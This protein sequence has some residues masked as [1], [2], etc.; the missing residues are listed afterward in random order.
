MILAAISLLLLVSLTFRYGPA[1]PPAPGGTDTLEQVTLGGLRQWISMRGADSKAPVLLFLHGGPGSA[2]LA[3]LRLQVP[4]L[5]QHFVVVNW[6]QPGAGKSASPGFDYGRLSIGQMVSD[7]HELVAYLK[8]RFGVEKIYL[9]GFSWGTVIG[10]SLAQQYPQDFLAYISVSQVVD[11][12]QGER[13]SLEFVRQKA[14]QDGNQH[15]ITALAGIN[16][17]Y[18]STD[19]LQQ[20]TTERN[21]LLHYGGVYHN[22]SSYAHEIWLLL[23]AHEYSLVEVSLWPGHSRASLKQ[24]WPEVMRVNF[25]ETVTNV[26]CPI[27]FFVGRYDYNA[28]GQLTEAY[29]QKLEAPA[30]KKLVWF[31]HSAHDIFYDEPQRLVQEVL[32][33][34]E[35]DNGGSDVVHE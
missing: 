12:A 14:A 6:D 31:E 28:P 9:M 34:L 10:L 21:W 7:A 22:T 33:V 30:G 35:A 23:E 16:P 4:E 1:H 32:A 19:W 8:A 20:V 2:N 29:Y 5:E 26:D 18:S 27:Y 15:A 11:P 24:M 25:F 13:L 3:K 17:A